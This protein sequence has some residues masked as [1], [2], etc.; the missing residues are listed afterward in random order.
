MA[1]TADFL[2]AP[3]HWDAGLGALG[4]VGGHGGAEALAV[5]AHVAAARVEYAAV[6]PRPQRNRRVAALEDVRFEDGALLGR[7]NLAV[8]MQCARILWMT[9]RLVMKCET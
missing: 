4:G 8:R 3:L 2:R 1:L 9:F 6:E 7:P 5:P